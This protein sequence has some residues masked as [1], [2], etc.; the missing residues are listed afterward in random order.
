MNN[1]TD[2]GEPP[3]IGESLVRQWMAFGQWGLERHSRWGGA[4]LDSPNGWAGTAA[5]TV[6]ALIFFIVGLDRHAALW[7]WMS[8]HR[9]L[10]VVVQ[11]IAALSLGSLCLWLLAYRPLTG[12]SANLAAALMAAL[13]IAGL[14]LLCDR[15]ND[16]L[17]TTGGTLLLVIAW[18]LTQM[19][20][21][22]PYIVADLIAM[23]RRSER[24]TMPSMVPQPDKVVTPTPTDPT[25]QTGTIDGSDHSDLPTRL[26]QPSRTSVP[27]RIN[28]WFVLIIGGTFLL[29]A[30][31]T[32]PMLSLTF[33]DF[34]SANAT[35]EDLASRLEAGGNGV[36]RGTEV[37]WRFGWGTIS[38]AAL[39]IAI[40][41]VGWFRLVFF[42]SS[43]PTALLLAGAALFI[44]QLIGV[45]LLTTEAQADSGIIVG[46]IGFWVSQIA[47]AAII[48]SLWG[49]RSRSSG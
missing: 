31:F 24:P 5:I 39:V 38:Y 25:T 23:S 46:T 17:M 4:T 32:L 14:A 3:N 48:G 9:Q 28:A 35:L 6:A 41:L 18:R 47:F 13:F 37:A 21:V 40:G 44:I 10:F 1:A 19:A 26:S 2:R 42:H 8:G 22:G 11:S 20:T 33:G 49:L 15:A 36:S 29:V 12:R 27:I 16:A 45:I 34:G 43:V 7:D 30:A